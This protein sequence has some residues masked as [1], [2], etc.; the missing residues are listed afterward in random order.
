MARNIQKFEIPLFDGKTNFMIWQCTVQDILVQQGLD[1]ALEDEKPSNINER[2]WSQIQKKAV[3]TIRLAL[4]PEIKCNVLKETT[5]KALWEKL[6]SIYASKSLTNRLCLKMEL[7]QLKMEIGENLHDHINHFNQ[8]VCQLLNVNEK[9]YNEEQAMLLL[10]SL[11]MSYKSL[12][13][14]L[15]V[16]KTSLKLDQVTSAL[17][18]NERMMKMRILI[19]KVMY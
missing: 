18:E 13:Q 9:I 6:E 10:A 3:S 17:R 2:E 12:V 15:L 7:Y 14:T 11:P 5:P 19:L 16:G 1:Q 8:L 4:T